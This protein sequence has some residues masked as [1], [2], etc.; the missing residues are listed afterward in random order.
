MFNNFKKRLILWSLDHKRILPW[1][2]TR[3][4]YFIWLR[5]VMLQQTRVEQGASYYQKFISKYPTVTDLANASLDEVYKNWEGLGYYSR[6]KN[7]LITAQTV[8]DDYK[9][10]FPVDYHKILSLKGIGEY[11]AAAIV[12]FAYDQPY[13]VLDGN[14][15]RVLSR[16]FGVEHPIDTTIGKKYFKKLAQDCLDVEQPAQYNQAI[17][18]FG[19]VICKPKLPLCNHCPFSSECIAYH[20]DRISDLPFKS[21]KMIK[22][23]RYFN[24]LVLIQ[25][26]KV[27]IQQRNKKDIWQHLFQFP[28]I[29]SEDKLLSKEELPKEMIDLASIIN[30]SK[31]YSQTLTHRNIYA[32]F[33]ELEG[34][35]FSPSNE[36]VLV[37]FEELKNYGFPKIIKDYLSEKYNYIY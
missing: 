20:Q 11:T 31:L 22:Q 3:D 2:K 23:N 25:N 35:N 1:S 28:L 10:K 36:W 32:K 21:K 9:G 13:S 26:E 30:E 12:S 14:V 7:L 27:Y 18:D 19:A 17:I 37:N 6:A 24:Y 15:F 33:F 4:P 5:E 8:R 16:Y 34:N 29:E